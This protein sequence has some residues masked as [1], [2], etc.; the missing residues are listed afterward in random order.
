[1]LLPANP[2]QHLTQEATPLS[3]AMRVGSGLLYGLVCN[4][5]KSEIVTRMSYKRQGSDKPCGEKCDIC[6]YIQLHHVLLLRFMPI[7]SH[8][9]SMPHCEEPCSTFSTVPVGMD[10]LL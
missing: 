2:W 9:P 10:G 6:S 3:K 1:M 4:K 8:L 7:A 5:I